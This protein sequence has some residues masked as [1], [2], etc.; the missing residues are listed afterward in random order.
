MCVCVLGVRFECVCVC[1]CVLG[2]DRGG[3]VQGMKGVKG[4]H[5]FY[6]VLNTYAV[7]HYPAGIRHQYD[8]I[9]TRCAVMTL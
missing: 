6:G 7:E 8:V 4:A 1:V 3:G 2:V 9:L 5:K